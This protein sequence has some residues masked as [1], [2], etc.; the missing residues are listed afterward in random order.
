MAAQQP[1]LPPHGPGRTGLP[2]SDHT[3]PGKRPGKLC[4]LQTLVTRAPSLPREPGPEAR[5]T[6]GIVTPGSRLERQGL[7][8]T[9]LKEATHRGTVWG[10]EGTL[11]LMWGCLGP[12]PFTVRPGLFPALSALVFSPERGVRFRRSPGAACGRH[13][14]RQVSGRQDPA[15]TLTRLLVAL[16][17]E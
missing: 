4:I 2:T 11:T 9:L 5:K 3:R 13:G 14:D 15:P 17:V 8:A 16:S 6:S 12:P 10:K 1:S 7:T